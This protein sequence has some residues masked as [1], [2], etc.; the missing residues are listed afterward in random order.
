MQRVNHDEAAPAVD[1]PFKSSVSEADGAA[2]RFLTSSGIR[3][4]LVGRGASRA[5]SRASSRGILPFKEITIP[6][7]S[8]NAPSEYSYPETPNFS[9]G[10]TSA[11][12]PELLERLERLEMALEEE[13]KAR[14]NVEQRLQKIKE[15]DEQEKT[16]VTSSG[17]GKGTKKL[18][19]A[20]KAVRENSGRVSSTSDE[21]VV[22][23]KPPSL[24]ASSASKRASFR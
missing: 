14:A 9:E 4:A 7:S 5:S 13:K 20:K 21:R 15:E 1:N 19:G 18:Q 2:A 6:P 23:T 8:S 12:D 17:A 24:T 16:S 11:I 22:H 10:G 3:N